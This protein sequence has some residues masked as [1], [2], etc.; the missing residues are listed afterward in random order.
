MSLQRLLFSLAALAAVA[1][2]ATLGYWQLGRADFKEQREQATA[3]AL[4]APPQPVAAVLGAPQPGLPVVVEAQAGRY[5]DPPLLLDNQVRGRVNGTLVYRPFQLPSGEAVLVDLGWLAWSPD[6]RMPEL[7]LPPEGALPRGLLAHWPGQALA[8]AP[9]PARPGAGPWLLPRI[10]RE[11]LADALALELFDGVL[12]LDADAGHGYQH[13]GAAVVER[14]P[15]ERHRGY[16]VQ[17]FALAALVAIVYG[18]LSWK[19]RRRRPG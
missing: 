3:L 8:L 9:L 10:E 12:V 2:F 14:M 19:H 13:S 5:L 17:W 18:V 6:R 7:S 1:G 4:A 15:P 11:A 16:A